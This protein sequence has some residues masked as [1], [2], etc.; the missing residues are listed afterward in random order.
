MRNCRFLFASEQSGRIVLKGELRVP[1]EK[2]DR[3]SQRTRRL[4]GDAFLALLAE[5]RYDAITVQDVIERANVGR[6]TYYAH[7]QDKEALLLSEIE[8]VVHLLGHQALAAGEPDQLLLPSLALFRHV[9]TF[10]PVYQTLGWA[11][12]SD[13]IFKKIQAQVAGSIEQRLASLVRPNHPPAVPLPVVAHFVAGTFL[14]QLKWWMDGRM[15]Y[16]PEQV[17]AIFWRLVKPGVESV[18]GAEL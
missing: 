15:V 4:L 11:R 2:Q 18:V 7:F 3:R 12:G 5:K 8:R 10:Q 6:T 16:T 1:T 17:D 13:V 9:R 14:T